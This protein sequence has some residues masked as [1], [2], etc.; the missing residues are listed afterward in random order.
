[1]QCVSN[2]IWNEGF[3]KHNYLWFQ[4][5]VRA[6]IV[7]LSSLPASFW[8]KIGLLYSK[9]NSSI[10]IKKY[11][12]KNGFQLMVCE[13]YLRNLRQVKMKSKPFALGLILLFRGLHLCWK[14]FRSLWI[15]SSWKSLTWKCILLFSEN[16]QDWVSWLLNVDAFPL[17]PLPY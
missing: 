17:T 13:S 3:W 8:G 9:Q 4:S 16:Q 6:W 14:I 11:L 10:A 7:C 1:M 15:E 5:K 12:L 2:H